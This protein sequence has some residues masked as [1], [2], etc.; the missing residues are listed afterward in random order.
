[1]A[2]DLEQT[3]MMFRFMRRLWTSMVNLLQM[4]HDRQDCSSLCTGSDTVSFAAVSKMAFG[5]RMGVKH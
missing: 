4:I 3:S 1:M 5:N 2:S